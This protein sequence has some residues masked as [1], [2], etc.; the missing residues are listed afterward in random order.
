MSVPK[1]VY[2]IAEA[3]EALGI[4]R[5]GIEVLIHS[6]KLKAK[7]MGAH[8]RIRLVDLAKYVD[9]LDDAA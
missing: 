7:R 2:T 5:H 1:L 6:R 9:S 4:A 3:A 8:Y